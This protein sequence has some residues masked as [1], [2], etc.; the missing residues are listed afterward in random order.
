MEQRRFSEIRN[1]EAARDAIPRPISQLDGFAGLLDRPDWL[2]NPFWVHLLESQC[3][4][5]PVHNYRVTCAPS[6]HCLKTLAEFLLSKRLL[7]ATV[8]SNS[9]APSKNK[10]VFMGPFHQ[11]EFS[12]KRRAG[13][14]R[15]AGRPRDRA[16]G[17]S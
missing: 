5:A 2:D 4:P 6:D 16:G 3:P 10:R 15:G 8:S 9:F 7:L 13:E 1:S 17:I 12:F 11:D 14:V